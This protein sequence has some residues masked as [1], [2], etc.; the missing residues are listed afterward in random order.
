MAPLARCTLLAFA[1]WATACGDTAAGSVGGVDSASGGGPALDGGTTGGGASA[2]AGPV[3][4]PSD[5]TTGGGS[6]GADGGGPGD[7][8]GSD[9]AAGGGSAPA[10]GAG[11][12]DASGGGSTD[13]STCI[14]DCEGKSCGA[15]GC[16]GTC[17]TCEGACVAGQCECTASCEAVE[18]GGDGCGGTC[19]ACPSGEACDSGTCV[20]I[21]DCSTAECGDDGCGGSCGACGAGLTCKGQACEPATWTAVLIQDLWSGNCSSFNASG[22]DITAAALYDQDGQLISYFTEVI[23]DIGTA[24]CN[25]NYTSIASVA[26]DPD[27]NNSYVALQGG[28]VLG[29]FGGQPILP[30][31]TVGV[32]EIGIGEGGTDEPY[33]VYLATGLDCPDQ[34]DPAGCVKLLTESTTGDD[35]VIVP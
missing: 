22:A 5:S 4:D 7:P 17:G 9:G 10:D 25:N 32:F 11:A 16:G 14:P 6:A 34:P 29:T 28:W 24:T 8:T 27:A 20:C 18:C 33:Q 19:G 26:G 1:V 3:G 31:F 13:G 2:D 35:E 12:A 30:G 21:P 23:G 15:D